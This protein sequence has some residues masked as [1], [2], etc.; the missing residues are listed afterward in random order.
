MSLGQAGRQA[1]GP[2]TLSGPPL[3]I[4][5]T[6]SHTGV[7]SHACIGPSLLATTHYLLHQLLTRGPPGAVSAPHAATAA[8]LRA[9][10]RKDLVERLVKGQNL[11]APAAAGGGMHLQQQGEAA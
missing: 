1:R 2:L 5:S 7:M 11:H 6:M 10:V 8:G 4:C 3:A 9:A